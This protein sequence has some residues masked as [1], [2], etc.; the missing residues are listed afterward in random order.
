MRLN[1]S[2]GLTGAERPAP[3]VTHLPV[4]RKPRFPS[5]GPLCHVTRD[6]AAGVL[7]RE[8]WKNERATMWQL[9][10]LVRLSLRSDVPSLFLCSLGHTDH[11]WYPGVGGAHKGVNT[12]GQGSLRMYWRP[13]TTGVFSQMSSEC[14]CVGSCLIHFKN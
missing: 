1:S 14:V 13:A 3:C 12:R 6:T 7:Q 10:S 2:K 8:G 5:Q 4:G 9:N 11:P